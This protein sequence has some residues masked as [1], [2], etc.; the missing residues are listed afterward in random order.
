MPKLLLACLS[1]LV[2]SVCLGMLLLACA[3]PV[4]AQQP[5]LA[6][7][8]QTVWSDAELLRRQ[9]YVEVRLGE[10][11]ECK[12]DLILSG[13][14]SYYKRRRTLGWMALG[15]G[16]FLGIG[17]ATIGLMMITSETNSGS[18]NREER[19]GVFGVMAGGLATLSVGLWAQLSLRGDN[20]NQTKI[21]ALTR[22]QRAFDR[23]RRELRRELL[24]RGRYGL[25]P[26]VR[27]GGECALLATAALSW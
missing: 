19:A 13:R 3:Q 18:L 15:V 21:D 16:S 4:A 7:V 20:L 14:P 17:A 2:P 5:V 9:D 24:S 12:R 22:L 25:V 27:P 8:V 26:V 23:E 1:A 10:V 6:P 11:Q